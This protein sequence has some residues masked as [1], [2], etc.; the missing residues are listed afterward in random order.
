M[1]KKSIKAYIRNRKTAM[2]VSSIVA[3]SKMSADKTMRMIANMTSFGT[4][5]TFESGG[6]MY[7][8]NVK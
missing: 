3:K 4:I 2:T 8:R 1:N 7:I 6:I 5:E